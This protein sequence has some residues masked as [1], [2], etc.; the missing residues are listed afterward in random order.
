MPGNAEPAATQLAG[1]AAAGSIGLRLAAGRVRASSP[2]RNARA[3]PAASRPRPGGTRTRATSASLAWWSVT[4][5]MA[6]LIASADSGLLSFSSSS[7]I[8][9]TSL[10]LSWLPSRANSGM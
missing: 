2:G 9:F 10:S 3:W 5:A 6:L 8:A 1:W 7:A 4:V